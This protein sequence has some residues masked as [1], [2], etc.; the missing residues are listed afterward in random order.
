MSTKEHWEQD[1]HPERREGERWVTNIGPGQ[2]IS[3]YVLPGK[4][5]GKVA[6]GRGGQVVDDWRPLF[7]TQRETP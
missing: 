1:D 5:I 2:D 3:R 4:R 7:C 6:F